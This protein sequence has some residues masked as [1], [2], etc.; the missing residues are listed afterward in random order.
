MGKESMRTLQTMR[1]R[2]KRCWLREN[3][4]RSAHSIFLARYQSWAGRVARAKGKVV[5]DVLIN[6]DSLWW[7]RHKIRVEVLRRLEE[8]GSVS[9]GR[10]HWSSSM[11]T[12]GGRG[13]RT[14]TDG[15]KMLSASRLIFL[16]Q[17]LCHRF[18]RKRKQPHNEDALAPLTESTG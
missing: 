1:R 14:E 6:R 10:A 2:N 11:D 18:Q 12:Y 5:H 15:K 7:N 13:P 8:T 3:G 17:K 9:L 4:R 16:V